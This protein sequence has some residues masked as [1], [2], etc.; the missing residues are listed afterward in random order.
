MKQ[1]H[2]MVGN[3]GTGKTTT[4]RKLIKE[5]SLTMYVADDMICE[6]VNLGDY[7]PE[8]WGDKYWPVYSEIKNRV[9]ETALANGFSI[10]VDSTNTSKKRR[11]N[12]TA[13]AKELDVKITAYVH[14]DHEA[15]LERRKVE[16]RGQTPEMW[17]KV[18]DD[19]Q[20]KY[21]ETTLD[22]GFFAVN[23]I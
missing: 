4:A 9:A 13:K 6:M 5:H 21:E 18:H 19:L 7:S 23:V 20:V 8:K 10:I 14:L 17:Q 16:P 15:G 1:I 2:L 22:E 12:W 11:A 3:I